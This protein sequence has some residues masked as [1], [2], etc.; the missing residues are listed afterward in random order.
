[1]KKYSESDFN[2]ND[3]GELSSLGEFILKYIEIFDK[4]SRI[5]GFIYLHGALESQL[6][7]LWAIFLHNNL[8]EKFVPLQKFWGFLDCIDLLEQVNVLDKNT[9]SKLLAFNTGRNYIAHFMTNRFKLKKTSEKALIDQFGKG[10]DAYKDLIKI[11]NH[12]VNGNKSSSFKIQIK[13]SGRPDMAIANVIEDEKEYAFTT[14]STTFVDVFSLGLLKEKNRT[15]V[16]K[17]FAQ[18]ESGKFEPKI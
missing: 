18:T 2:A 11:R 12:L 15:Y 13:A 6:F 8:Q 16:K 7:A 1:M 5:E 17:L 10:L 4:K 3:K 14:T 9:I